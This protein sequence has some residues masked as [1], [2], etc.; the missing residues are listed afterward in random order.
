MRRHA[1]TLILHATGWAFIFAG[2]VAGFVPFVPGFLLIIIGIYLISLRSVWLKRKLDF[3]RRHYPGL[4]GAINRFEEWVS[5]R[6]N[7]AMFVPRK[8]LKKIKK[9]Q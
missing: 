1:S 2:M 8:I 7:Q 4:D 6:W 5:K 3:I 9:N